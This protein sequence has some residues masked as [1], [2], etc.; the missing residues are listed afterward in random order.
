LQK[1]K[2]EKKA[3]PKIGEGGVYHH[4]KKNMVDRAGICL[5]GKKKTW[6]AKKGK[7]G[8]AQRKELVSPTRKKIPTTTLVWEN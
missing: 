2:K 7:R 6:M 3:E 8:P 5:E 4:K 1:K